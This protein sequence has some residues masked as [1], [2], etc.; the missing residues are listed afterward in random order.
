[1]NQIIVTG[2]SGFIGTNLVKK[3][4]K[5]R[6]NSVV[7]LDKKPPSIK[8]HNFNHIDIDLGSRNAVDYL[9]RNISLHKNYKVI[10][11]AAQTSSQISMED[12]CQDL[13]SNLISLK[14]IL[15]FFECSE[16]KPSLL[17]FS[18][19]MAVYGD[20][21]LPQSGFSED[22]ACAPTSVYGYTKLISE[23]ILS[24]S[25]IPSISA[26]LFNV[27]GI[28]QDLK[29]MKQGMLSIYM[30]DMIKNGKIHIKGSTERTRD[31]IHVDDVVASFINLLN[32]S[33]T[34]DITKHEVVNICTGIETSVAT[35][36][37]MMIEAYYNKTS[38][39]CSSFS[40]GNT[41]GDMFRSFGN[42]NK[43]RI[44]YNI[45]AVYPLKDGISD[46]VEWAI[47]ALK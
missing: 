20:A 26:R 5:D 12:P 28:G 6:T 4:L 9:I 43:K 15:D 35:I 40:E 44:K 14:N 33:N 3:L 47:E 11:L 1:M 31:F 41:P 19:S 22:Q 29:N 18:S 45:K 17:L 21:P 38:I 24:K 10:H 25:Q 13:N 30:A 32:Q 46:M 16:Y 27:Y 23:Y 2:S 36:T 37:E 7:G 34:K 8:D 39:N 42:T